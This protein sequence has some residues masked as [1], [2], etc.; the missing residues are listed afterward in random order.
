M[1]EAKI[2]SVNA[3]IVLEISNHQTLTSI[4]TKDSAMDMKIGVGDELIAII[5]ASQIIIG[6]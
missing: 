2:G 6:V 3:E 4:I 5:K 1:I